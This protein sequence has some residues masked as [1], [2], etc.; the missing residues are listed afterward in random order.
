M[1]NYMKSVVEKLS[2]PLGIEDTEFRVQSINYK[3]EA[4]MLGYK[5]ARVDMR[6]LDEATGGMWQRSHQLIGGHLYSKI[7]V[8]DEDSQQWVG[9]TDVGTESMSEAT[10]GEAS[11][12][13]KRAGFNW[14]IGRN[15]YDLPLI[16]VK[17][18]EGTEYKKDGN[19]N[20]ATWG[21]KL[22]D[23][24]WGAKYNDDGVLISLAAKDQNGKLRYNWSE[25][26]GV[27]KNSI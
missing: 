10:K 9:K 23:W 8:W 16:A 20:K 25:S 7:E 14:G 4:I 3:G 15:L 2:K 21:L 17:L 12:S 27:I 22:R 18:I 6:K 19:R 13:F 24:T 26:K 11:D 1:G 5:D